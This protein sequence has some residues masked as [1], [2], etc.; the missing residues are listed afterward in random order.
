VSEPLLSAEGVTVHLGGAAVLR[1]VSIA[2]RAGEVLGVFGPSGAGK[3]TLFRALAGEARLS[4]GRVRLD[5]LDVTALPLWERARR[6]LGYVPQTPSVLLDLTALENL[7]V[8]R[9][10]ARPARPTHG[11]R[12]DPSVL[13]ADL[14]LEGRAG[15]LAGALSGGERRRL[16]LAR[17]LSAAPRVLLCDEP[18]AAIDPHGAVQAGARLRALC[19]AGS[20]VVIADH[21]AAA[22]LRLC[23]RA[24]LLLD[25]EVAVVADP[26]GFCADPR[27]RKHYASI[28]LGPGA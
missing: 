11:A 14:G 23:D 10:L 27:V 6:G 4:E 20:A 16:E 15:V 2:V 18:F 3:S 28:D 13:L 12:P 17:A 22:A 24:A 21:H 8:F 7:A 26:P 19:A 1:R 25:G 9:R 5:G